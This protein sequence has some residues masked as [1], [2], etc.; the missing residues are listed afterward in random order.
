M[1]SRPP[2]SEPLILSSKQPKSERG[3]IDSSFFNVSG[4]DIN[5]VPLCGPNLGQF[6]RL[7]AHLLITSR[8]AARNVSSRAHSFGTL[9]VADISRRGR[10]SFVK[11]SPPVNS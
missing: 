9:G 10:E 11:T 2:Y 6:Q 4:K 7:L 1:V 3:G 5:A 8:T